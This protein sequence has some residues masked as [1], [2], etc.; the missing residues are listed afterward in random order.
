M[1]FASRQGQG[2][3]KQEL[4]EV[5]RGTNIFNSPRL[6]HIARARVLTPVYQPTD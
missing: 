4:E 3:T 2:Y 1:S 5:V 6:L